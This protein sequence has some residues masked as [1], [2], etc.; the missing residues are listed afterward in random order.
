MK[1]YTPLLL[2]AIFVLQCQSSK[3][4]MLT[5]DGFPQELVQFIPYK[6]NPVF[7]AT[8]ASTWDKEIRERGYI[9]RED[10]IY[11]L[12]YTGYTNI[13]SVKWLGYATSPDGYNWTRYKENPIYNLGW[14]E[15]ICVVKSEGVYYMFAEGKG[16]TAHMLT[17]TDRIHWTE[18]GN[19]DIRRADG[20]SIS[21]GSF[22]TPFVM[23]EKDLWYL[24]YEREDLGIWLATSK[25]LKIWTN[26]QDEPVLKMGPESYDQ[27]AVAMN[28]VVKYKGRYY[29]YYHASAFKDWH[30]WSTNV[31]VSDDLLHW[32]KYAGN[33]VVGNNKSSGILVNDGKRYRLYTMHPEVNV[34]FPEVKKTPK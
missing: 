3:K 16:D 30:E 13:D 20:N 21:K 5:S 18:Q 17:S 10:G 11:H 24:F 27:Y 14:V 6:N 34:Y 1:K 12:W 26:V 31:A 2:S 33:P 28:Q 4:T 22:G 25:D 23:K 19:L 15:D 32:K 29:G 9:L 8:G 7:S